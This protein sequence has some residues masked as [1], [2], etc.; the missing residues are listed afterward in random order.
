VIEMWII[1]LIVSNA[2]ITTNA[3]IS[4]KLFPSVLPKQVRNLNEFCIGYLCNGDMWW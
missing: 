3:F 2:K 1:I 4:F